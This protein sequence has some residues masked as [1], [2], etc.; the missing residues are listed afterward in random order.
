MTKALRKGIMT[1]S[2]LRNKFN[3]KRNQ[4]NWE[5]YKKQRNFCTS[6][7]KKSK[8]N[9]FRNLNI[10]DLSDNKKFWKKIAP[11]FSNNTKTADTIILTKDDEIIRDEKKVATF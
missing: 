6:L 9:F 2:R 10:K 5:K 7:L 8:Q 4:S 1:R 11:L 3:L